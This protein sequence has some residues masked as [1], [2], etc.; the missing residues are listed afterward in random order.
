MKVIIK[1]TNIDIPSTIR[2]Y[3]DSRVSSIEKLLID[4]E[5]AVAQIRIEIGRPSKHHRKGEVHYAEINLSVG[6]TLFR[7]AVEHERVRPALDEARDDIKGQ[8]RRYK[9]KQRSRRRKNKT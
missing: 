7:S 3:I 1:S 8:L 5:K 4:K 2:E 9:T 6:N